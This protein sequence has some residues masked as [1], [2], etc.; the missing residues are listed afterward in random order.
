[1]PIP[2]VTEQ[3]FEREVIRSELPVLVEFSDDRPAAR[4]SAVELEGVAREVEGRAK[5]FRVDVDRS[6]RLAALLKIQNVP[7]FVIFVKGRPVV[8]ETG[9]MRKAELLA[10]LEPHLPRPEGAIKAA[11]LAQL[12]RQGQVVP[13]DTREVAAFSR[14]HI[15]GAVNLPIE[16]IESR[17]A[18]LHMLAGEPV[19]YCRSGDR[20]RD[21]ADKLAQSG[22]PVAYLEGGLLAWEAALLPIERPD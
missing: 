12:L 10:L 16:E 17:L 4:A 7:T 8:G 3:D 14:A 1:M 2:L 22:V 11:E 13:V 5:V 9:V 18:E 6:R 21:M 19:L 20:S 15:P